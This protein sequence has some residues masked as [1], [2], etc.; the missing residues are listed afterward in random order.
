MQ[1]LL[2]V[3]GLGGIRWFI[4]EYRDSLKRKGHVESVLKTRAET[5]IVRWVPPPSSFYKI[6]CDVALDN[7]KGRMGIGLLIRDS[8]GKVHA[9]ASQVVDF[10]FDPVVGESIAALKA[11]EFCKNRGLDRIMVEGDSIQVVQSIN[12]PGLNWGK[13]G[14]IVADIHEVLRFFREWKVCHTPRDANSAAHTLAKEGIQVVADRFWLD[15]YPN[16]IR[17]IV[18]SELPTLIH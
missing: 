5:S 9:A 12:K 8:K 10:I 16:S 3:F 1:R 2:D 13:Y 18:L 15:C 11:V 4:N 6:N 14:H 7:K 17:E